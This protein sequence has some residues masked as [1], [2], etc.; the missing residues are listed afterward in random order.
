VNDDADRCDAF[1]VLI[2]GLTQFFAEH[3]GIDLVDGQ[4][5]TPRPAFLLNPEGPGLAVRDGRARRQ[6]W[7]ASRR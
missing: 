7:P 4:G 6:A 5:R 2:S 1:D 3:V